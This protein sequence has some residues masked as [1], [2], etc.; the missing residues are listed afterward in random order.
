M[1][2]RV[3]LN[4]VIR[5]SSF[6]PQEQ[7]QESE[8]TLKHRTAHDEQRDAEINYQPGDVD[9]RR[10]KRRRSRIRKM[11]T[12]SSSGRSRMISATSAGGISEKSSR[13]AVKLRASIRLLISGSKILPT[14]I[15]TGL[16][17]LTRFTRSRRQ[18]AQLRFRNPV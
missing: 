1:T 10:N 14:M 16:T 3:F 9:Q 4:F 8:R 5:A 6:Y 15:R 7:A 13:S 18:S 11:I 2:K 12:R 17:G